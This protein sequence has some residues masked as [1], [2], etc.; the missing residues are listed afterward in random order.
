MSKKSYKGRVFEIWLAG[1][2]SKWWTQDREGGARDDVFWHTH[3]SG[4]R[5]T[6]R[7]RK[8]KKTKGLCGDICAT[9]SIGEPLLDLITIEAKKG[10][11]RSTVAD[12][13]DKPEG[14]AE[15]T[16]EKWFKQ[17]EE[18]HVQAG[19][20]SWMVVAKRD[21]RETM[22][23]MPGELKD[24]LDVDEG[25]IRGI[26]YSDHEQILDHGEVFIISLA[27][28]LDRIMP[29]DVERLAKKW[30]EKNQ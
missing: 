11:S 12:I 1:E 28:W 16:Y 13:L 14:A 21:R 24:K 4:G 29:W 22:V 10:Y 17:A 26:I 15:Q 30:K 19:S 20:F 9:D 5:A 2:L 3:D 18:S 27:D 8:G 6:K 7:S 23:Y 25:Q